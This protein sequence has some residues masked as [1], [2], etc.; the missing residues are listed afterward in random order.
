MD[1][2]ALPNDR[3][4]KGSKTKMAVVMPKLAK[5]VFTG[6]VKKLHGGGEIPTRDELIVEMGHDSSNA[7]GGM[8]GGWKDGLGLRMDDGAGRNGAAECAPACRPADSASGR[9]DYRRSGL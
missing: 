4:P 9:E 1:W 7:V 5:R 8:L 2:N 6:V 3:A